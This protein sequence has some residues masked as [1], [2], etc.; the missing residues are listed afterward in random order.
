MV[1]NPM[2]ALLSTRSELIVRWIRFWQ[3]GAA[4][5]R[6]AWHA[7]R[8]RNGIALQGDTPAKASGT[9]QREHCKVK[10]RF[11]IACDPPAQRSSLASEDAPCK[12]RTTP[13]RAGQ[14][15]R[16]AQLILSGY[17]SIFSTLPGLQLV[18]FE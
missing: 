6:M 7:M 3:D 15:R 18:V 12:G 4:G 2:K 10:Q 11:R 1:T 17:L 13:Q 9:P 5:F 16:H 8:R 14:S